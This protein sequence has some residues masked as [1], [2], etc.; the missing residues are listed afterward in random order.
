MQNIIAHFAPKFIL[1]AMNDLVTDENG[2][3]LCESKVHTLTYDKGEVIAP[4]LARHLEMYHGIKP[5]QTDD[6]GQNTFGQYKQFVEQEIQYD[7]ETRDYISF[8]RHPID[9]KYVKKF[10]EYFKLGLEVS[11]YAIHERMERAGKYPHQ[12][13][14]SLFTSNQ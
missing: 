2:I 7:G 6:L 3:K 1:D 8:P 4:T 5:R 12:N 13:L 14:A 10:E 11:P 9:N